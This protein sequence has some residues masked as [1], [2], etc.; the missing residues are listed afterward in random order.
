MR[1]QASVIS[2]FF[3]SCGIKNIVLG[4]MSTT[5]VSLTEQ[6]IKKKESCVEDVNSGQQRE[7]AGNFAKSC[8][9]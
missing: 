8:N 9:A 5:K 1:M 6:N 7:S 2:R 3:F 4:F